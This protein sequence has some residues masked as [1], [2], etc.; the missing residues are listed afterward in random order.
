[1]VIICR[2]SGGLRRFFD[3]H[4]L[5]PRLGLLDSSADMPYEVDDLLRAIAPR[6]TLLITPQFDRE[7]NITEVNATIAKARPA[8]LS[9]NSVHLSQVLPREGSVAVEVTGI[10]QITDWEGHAS[11]SQ[12]G[13][14]QI[15]QVAD[16]LALQ[17]ASN[18][19][20]S[21]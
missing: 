11:F 10:T 15:Q 4:A 20:S 6:P 12:F 8:W 13:F 5:L 2:S 3:W 17:S 14:K 9:D 1:M 7:A 16:W 19:N 21:R 18:G